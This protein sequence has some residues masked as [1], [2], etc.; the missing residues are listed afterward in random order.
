M[1]EFTDYLTSLNRRSESPSFTDY[2]EDS[3]PSF[4][5]YLDTETR[6]QRYSQSV[7]P[8]ELEPTSPM[9]VGSA[10]TGGFWS[11]LTLGY[12]AP[13]RTPEEVEAMT[14]GELVSESIGH[15]AGGALPFIITSAVTGGY[16]APVAG[17]NYMNKAYKSLGLI[18]KYGDAVKRAE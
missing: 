7:V 2:L 4:T 16:G 8:Q 9:G 11:G 3:P 1:A 17:A 6:L 5:D 15:L 10:F 14:T 12:G 18:R 13:E